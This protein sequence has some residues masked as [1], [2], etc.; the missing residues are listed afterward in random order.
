[1]RAAH[2][3]PQ[4]PDDEFDAFER[5]TLGHTSTV[6]PRYDTK[7]GKTKSGH[8]FTSL[9]DDV[10]IDCKPPSEPPVSPSSTVLPRRDKQKSKANGG[11]SFTSLTD[12]FD[13][14]FEPRSQPPVSSLKSLRNQRKAS[15]GACS[16]LMAVGVF[17][18]FVSC[19]IL[20]MA[21]RVIE[22]IQRSQPLLP[23]ALPM[24]PPTSPPPSPP[25]PPPPLP[26]SRTLPPSQHALFPPVSTLAALNR[27]GASLS[28]TF[29]LDFEGSRCIDGM[30]DTFC[31]TRLNS[32]DPWL[33]VELE[34]TAL[35]RFVRVHNRDICQER[36]GHFQV[37]VGHAAG[38]HDFPAIKCIDFVAPAATPG[39][40]VGFMVTCGAIGKHVTLFLPG[41]QRTLNLGE[42]YVYGNPPPS[43]PP[44]PPSAPPALP[45]PPRPPR[46]PLVPQ[47]LEG[48]YSLWTGWTG[49]RL[50]DMFLYGD[51]SDGQYRGWQRQ[52]IDTW[53]DSLAAQ[54][55]R[56]APGQASNYDVLIGLIRRFP[57]DLRLTPPSDAVIIHLRVGDV[58]ENSHYN[59]NSFYQIP[60]SYYEQHVRSF[61]ADARLVVLVAGAHNKYDSYVHSSAYIDRV[62]AFFEERGYQVQLRLGNLPDDDVVFMARAS[63]FVQSGGGFSYLISQ[64]NQRMGGRVFCRTGHFQCRRLEAF[65]GDSIRGVTRR[66]E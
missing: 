65:T 27:I 5:A 56:M 3:T 37:W 17:C 9:A 4:D 12:D 45:S 52:H 47:R 7:K 54:Y 41:E 64:I 42:V 33:S 18:C 48:P 6:I 1:M 15:S 36:L 44:S 60:L 38:L 61:P 51:H 19:T 10:D 39:W 30:V 55:I 21:P 20:V 2:A 28:S 50:G 34:N 57:E 63:F 26:P 58:W 11:H 29:S 24:L 25:P 13:I 53:P 14:D 8:S 46:P 22:V 35:V 16:S 23:P 43:G 62:R 31:H 32:Q 66:S 40:R 49:Y 59:G